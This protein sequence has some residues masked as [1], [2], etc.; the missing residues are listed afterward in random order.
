ML[1]EG[2]YC[3]YLRKSRADEMREAIGEGETLA[4]HRQ[5]LDALAERMGVTIAKWYT[6]GIV[7]GESIADRPAMIEL[8]RDVK[9]GRWDG[10]LCMEV[11]RLS[12]GDAADQAEV[13]NAVMYSDTL[14]VTPMKVYDP[15]SE[16]DMEYFEFGLFMSRRE[17]KTINKRLVAGRVA[18]TREGQF[19]AKDAPFGYDKAVIDGMRTLRPNA[20]A[21]TVRMIC[22]WYA[23]GASYREVAGRLDAM[24]VNPLRSPYGWHPASV[25]NIVLNPVYRG[26]VSWDKSATRKVMQDGVLVRKYVTNSE[27]T[28]FRGLHPAI[29]KGELAE[30]VDARTA[31]APVRGD[32]SM[33]NP[34]AHVLVCSKCGVALKYSVGRGGKAWLAHYRR[35][36]GCEMRGALKSTVDELVTS[37]LRAVIAD[38]ELD[39]A[40]IGSGRERYARERERLL[41]EIDAA[42][43]AVSDNFDRMER[44]VI[45]EADF[46]ERRGV[47]DARADAA[48]RELA[49][50]TEPTPD[51]QMERIAS[52]HRA[53][54]LLED[55]DAPV[56]AVNTFLKSVVE[57]I[58]YTNEGGEIH[59][60][61]HLK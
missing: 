33:R 43:R 10:I 53:V 22:R 55:A 41:S 32:Y 46:V 9:A 18:A 25:R 51:E 60:D 3:A 39:I 5:T 48:E 16:S 13:G 27:P 6:D 57:R 8:L 45:S 37:S 36:P 29:V 7:S 20:D 24:G 54:E 12:R 52:L 59:L 49:S 1:A 40:N 30:A 34:Y 61:V 19:I 14:I 56:R 42:K 11:E 58:E 31:S 23:D 28:L 38:L 17:F 26:Y 4:H 2:R 21:E 47:L 35:R 50:L 15:R 44:G